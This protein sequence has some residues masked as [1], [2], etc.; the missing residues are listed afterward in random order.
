MLSVAN[1]QE[2]QRVSTGEEELGF[3]AEQRSQIGRDGEGI[4]LV[5]LMKKMEIGKVFDM[6]REE[7]FNKGWNKNEYERGRIEGAI[8]IPKTQTYK[9]K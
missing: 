7:R 3:H 2:T 8:I 4:C 6:G 9:K 5:P 1:R